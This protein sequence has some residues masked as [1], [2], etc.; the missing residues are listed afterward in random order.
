[1]PGSLAQFVLA[2]MLLLVI[3]ASACGGSD[4]HATS[5]TVSSSLSGSARGRSPT[6]V[7][8]TATPSP[9]QPSPVGLSLEILEQ[10]RAH[11][12]EFLNGGPDKVASP[13]LIRVVSVQQLTGPDDC[14]VDQPVGTQCPPADYNPAY[15]VFLVRN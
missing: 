7:G 13:E 11:L 8:N 3:A 10:L 2:I 4:K 15:R 1:M 5:P 14:L 6:P 12:F 9:P